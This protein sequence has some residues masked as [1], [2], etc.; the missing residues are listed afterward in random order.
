M[1]VPA[2][3]PGSAPKLTALHKLLNSFLLDV[4]FVFVFIQLD[5]FTWF[6]LYLCIF[7]ITL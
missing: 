7:F 2:V 4:R 3:S 1:V 5:P 6:K